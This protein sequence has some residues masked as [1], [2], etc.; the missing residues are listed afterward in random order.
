MA[1]KQQPNSVNTF[2][3]GVK[4][5]AHPL[6]TPNT[7]LTRL[8]NGTLVTNDGGDQFI[9]QNLQGSLEAAGLT[10][11]HELMG[12]EVFNNVAYIVSAKFNANNEF[13]TG[14]IGTYPSPNWTQ[15]NGDN[16]TISLPA[17]A[18]T[19]SYDLNI[20]AYRIIINFASSIPPSY[21]GAI[22]LNFTLTH[23]SSNT[24]YINKNQ[25]ATY[26]LTPASSGAASTTVSLTGVNTATTPFVDLIVYA[27]AP[28]NITRISPLV[29]VSNATVT[30][31]A[32]VLVDYDLSLFKLEDVYRPLHNF[33]TIKQPTDSD[34]TQPFNTAA[35][36]FKKWE[37]CEIK[38]QPDYDG[39]INIIINDRHNPV[40]IINS[41]FIVT[42]ARTVQLANR[43][44]FK[45]T[46]VYS[47]EE[48]NKT[49]LFLTYRSIPLFNFHKIV[50]GGNLS[51][52]GVRL[53][54]TYAT[55]EGNSTDVV[56][57]SN[58]IPIY[59]SS[60]G[61]FLDGG[62]NVKIGGIDTNIANKS[63]EFSLTNLDTD[64]AYIKLY[65][66]FYSSSVE[67]AIPTVVEVIEP[68][69]YTSTNLTIT[70][71]GFEAT[72]PYTE[73]QLNLQ[74]SKFA[75]VKSIE[76]YN[77]RLVLVGTTGETYEH[78]EFLRAQSLK[79]QVWEEEF[80][81]PKS[82]YFDA[83]A[84][85]DDV[86][87][88]RMET[89]EVAI[90]WVLPN[91]T[92]LPPLPIQG[93]DNSGV[94]DISTVTPTTRYGTSIPSGFDPVTGHNPYG[95]YRT[96]NGDIMR[97]GEI[98]VKQLQVL[99]P[100]DIFKDPTIREKTLGFYISVKKREPDCLMQGYLCN[101]MPVANESQLTFAMN[102]LASVVDA[103]VHSVLRGE[104]RRAVPYDQ[105]TPILTA[106][107]NIV[108]TDNIQIFP[109]NSTVPAPLIAT[110][111]R[112]LGKE[113]LTDNSIKFVPL[114][115]N[116][117]QFVQINRLPSQAEQNNA[118][119]QAQPTWSPVLHYAHGRISNNGANAEYISNYKYAFYSS[120]MVA[121][122]SRIEG[123]FINRNLSVN[124][125]RTD[126]AINT[127]KYAGAD[128]EYFFNT[129][130]VLR[131]GAVTTIANTTTAPQ[132]A[133]LRTAKAAYINEYLD[134][135]QAFSAVSVLDRSARGVLVDSGNNINNFQTSTLINTRYGSY[136]SI[137]FP[138]ATSVRMIDDDWYAYNTNGFSV[139]REPK[140]S[141]QSAHTTS[142]N[143]FYQR[144]RN[145]RPGTL[146]PGA[147]T[148]LYDNDRGSILPRP[149]WV[150][151]YDTLRKA[152]YYQAGQRY[153]WAVIDAAN[154]T[155]NGSFSRKLPVTNGD[156]YLIP[157]YK[158]VSYQLGIPEAPQVTGTTNNAID[159]KD[160][161]R[162]FGLAPYGLVMELVHQ[163]NYNTAYRH[164]E[165]FSETERRIYGK[166]RSFYPQQSVVNIV[167]TTQLEAKQ[168]NLG[169]SRY[170]SDIFTLPLDRNFIA[171]NESNFNRVW[172]SPQNTDIAFFNSY[173]DGRNLNYRDYNTDLGAFTKVIA[174]KNY[175]IG[176]F[177]QGCASIPIDEK[178]FFGSID[179]PIYV[180]NATLLGTKLS[181]ISEE[182]GTTQPFA[183]IAAGDKI[184][185]YDLNKNRLLGLSGKGLKNL[186]E[187]RVQKD[188][189]TKVAALR[190]SPLYNPMAILA[191]DEVTNNVYI[192]LF[193]KF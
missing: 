180:D 178:R 51:C 123:L 77:N 110:L 55:I 47:T 190:T 70:L 63:L 38:L 136:V 117:L 105:G 172:I 147:L 181:I 188:L 183:V 129:P 164:E 100:T 16:T 177:T 163:S 124:F 127:V 75:T 43:L 67:P 34:Y 44:Q 3:G 23:S 13:I 98:L 142:D 24:I 106:T 56:T 41:R 138:A 112:P 169:Y 160:D 101:S 64:Y 40:R 179:D 49:E 33:S 152:P 42:Q 139:A 83:K 143:A 72:R 107:T 1:Q 158:R 151:K 59:L 17:T 192:T 22:N 148:S 186:S 125:T 137:N 53:Y 87:Y 114:P 189:L 60:T 96:A 45:D 135:N 146:T 173:R 128:A 166:D 149:E 61:T 10:P 118:A 65:Y 130:V 176:V 122:P 182:Y 54:F 68:Y 9:L 26:T 102:D 78:L 155:T 66:S 157:T 19:A 71:T 162:W 30:A 193:N 88:W 69:S 187:Y 120:D 97:N 6:N 171:I 94:Y 99:D 165:Y 116:L 103:S 37:F 95:V 21:T 134:I 131:S 79:L 133:T 28:D 104:V 90:N 20:N 159:Y 62:S 113:N 93:I 35:F 140:T 167:S 80:A 36:K 27:L 108:Y 84:T 174:Y 73:A 50:D 161:N 14:E 18:V 39:S 81:K 76:Q 156:C 48:F 57:Q 86:G 46:N 15:L 32:A 12:V 109:P 191:Y 185:F 25:T 144:V 89:Y 74:G 184:L 29:G 119:N 132:V 7:I 170:T 5:D 31:V 2:N 4:T 145:L 85:H 150:S 141:I 121:V 52:G 11:G 175:L 82:Y 111:Q 168:A 154:T 115:A 91:G 153:D 92:V 58:L 126:G 8:L